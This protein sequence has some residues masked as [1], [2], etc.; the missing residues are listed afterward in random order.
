MEMIT[1][2][3]ITA[4]CLAAL[5]IYGVI[6]YIV[7]ERTH[8]IGIR[9]ALGAEKKNILQ[10]VLRQGLGLALA[11]AAVGLAGA[12]IVS[13]L[14]TGLLY[15]VHPADPVVFLI[16]PLLLFLVAIAATY[17]PARRAMRVDPMVALRHE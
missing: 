17:L 6:S 1:L 14:M 5:G 9:L 10:L 4:L 3:A 16:V 11:G 2:F 12:L 15:G 13:Q 7:S 8:E